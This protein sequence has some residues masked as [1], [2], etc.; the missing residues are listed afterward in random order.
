MKKK[1]TPVKKTISKPKRLI[2]N[3]LIAL[4][5][6]LFIV[7]L[8]FLLRLFQSGDNYSLFMNHPDELYSE[9]RIVNPHAGA[10][11]F[12]RLEYTEPARD[13]FLRMKPE[14]CFRIFVM[15]SSTVIGFPY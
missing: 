15:G 3:L 9:Y 13:I 7:L 5:P 14:G 6:V 1:N 4:M 11:Y 2:F 12:Q 8:E 10:K